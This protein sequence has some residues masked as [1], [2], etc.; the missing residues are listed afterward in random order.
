MR[1]QAKPAYRLRLLYVM[2]AV[3][4][5]SKK[6]RGDKDKFGEPGQPLLRC[7]RRSCYPC[8]LSRRRWCSPLAAL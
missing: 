6:D 1:K 4:R 2:S 5:K 7:R 3:L 8:L